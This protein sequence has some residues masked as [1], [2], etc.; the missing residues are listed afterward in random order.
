MVSTFVVPS[1]D[2]VAAV[3]EPLT[4]KMLTPL[5]MFAA[6]RFASPLIVCFPVRYVFAAI[7][8]L[9]VVGVM[10]AAAFVVT[11]A[12]KETLELPAVP[13]ET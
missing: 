2:T 10:V 4:P 6:V 1:C 11:D 9:L 12:V 7:S 3:S 5:L 8:M 13:L